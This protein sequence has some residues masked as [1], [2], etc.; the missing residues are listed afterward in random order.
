MGVTFF[1]IVCWGNNIRVRDRNRLDK[2]IKNCSS[3]MGEGAE[4]VE[5]VV[6]WRMGCK[7]KA[8]LGDPEHPLHRTLTG[9]RSSRS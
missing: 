4:L 3:V 2:L 5:A 6:R 1:G 7:L 9:Q 8:T